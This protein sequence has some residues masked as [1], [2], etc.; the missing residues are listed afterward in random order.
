LYTAAMVKSHPTP[1]E[2]LRLQRA[3]ARI[4]D[5]ARRQELIEFAEQLADAADAA[6]SADQRESH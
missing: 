5:P 2:G 1:E 3:F 6:K 4:V